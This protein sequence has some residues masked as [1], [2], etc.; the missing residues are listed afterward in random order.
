MMGQNHKQE[1][2]FSTF[3]LSFFGLAPH[4]APNLSFYTC[5]PPHINLVVGFNMTAGLCFSILTACTSSP[6]K[7]WPLI[8]FQTS[9][10]RKKFR[11]P[12]PSQL[13]PSSILSAS[14]VHGPNCKQRFS[15]L[16]RTL[17]AK[18]L[19]EPPQ[20]GSHKL[21]QGFGICACL[22]PQLASEAPAFDS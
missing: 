19:T 1:V 8:Q 14:K 16:E 3:R 10:P 13:E 9:T 22:D 21:R 7:L 6:M 15:C 2:F 20:A 18:H 5:S 12:A 4:F 11:T 17:K